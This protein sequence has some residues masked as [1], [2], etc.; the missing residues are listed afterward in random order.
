MIERFHVI[1]RLNNKKLGDYG[2]R[3]AAAE[4]ARILNEQTPA[5]IGGPV[6]QVRSVWVNAQ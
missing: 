2:D 6:Y 5:I 1:N 4:R 3:T